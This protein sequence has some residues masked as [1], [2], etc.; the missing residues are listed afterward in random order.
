MRVLLDEDTPVQLVA[1]LSRVLIGHRIDGVHE[2]GWSGKKDPQV[3]RDAGQTSQ[4]HQAE[5]QGPLH[6][7]LHR[8]LLKFN[9]P[10]ASPDVDWLGSHKVSGAA[11]T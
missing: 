5:G 3:L 7:L 9:Y 6:T 1:P 2:L 4:Y 11:M 10:S 8:F